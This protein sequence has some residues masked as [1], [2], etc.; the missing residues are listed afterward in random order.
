LDFVQDD[1][2]EKALSDMQTQLCV[3]IAQLQRYLSRWKI[4]PTAWWIASSEPIAYFI[5]SELPEKTSQDFEEVG[6]Q[7]RDVVASWRAET[8]RYL[9]TLIPRPSRKGKNTTNSLELA[10]TFFKCHWCTEPIMYPRILMHDCFLKESDAR[11]EARK[12]EENDENEN[13]VE[14]S[15]EDMVDDARG[16]REPRPSKQITP[17][18]VLPTLS[19]YYSLGIY[20]GREGV[21]IDEEASN[22]A[23]DIITICGEDPNLVTYH[24]MEEKHAILECLRCS[25]AMQAKQR[26]KS[27]RLVMRWTTAVRRSEIHLLIKAHLG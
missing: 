6:P 27:A 24:E 17:D 16:P 20:A 22:V 25:R 10:T 7:L 13:E 8:D 23:R 11:E 5:K 3:R 21:T 9:A 26:T 14:D 12:E 1:L 4:H 15:D 18:I 19:D 2:E